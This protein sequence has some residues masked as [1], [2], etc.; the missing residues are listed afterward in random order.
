[1]G[2]EPMTNRS[3]FS[4]LLCKSLSLYRL[5]YPGRPKARTPDRPGG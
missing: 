3:L 2:L 5:S 1:M 4:R